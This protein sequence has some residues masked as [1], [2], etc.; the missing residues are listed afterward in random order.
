MQDMA[1]VQRFYGPKAD[2]W[3]LGA[4]LYYMAYGTPPIYHPFAAANPP[5]GLFPHPD[6]ALNDV[7]RRTLVTNP[8]LRVDINTLLYHPFTR[9]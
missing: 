7:L 3:S 6:P 5:F 1:G 9:L 2:I 4:I 8:D